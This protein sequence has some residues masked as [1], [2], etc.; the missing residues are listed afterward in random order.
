MT[1]VWLINEKTGGRKSRETFPLMRTVAT[2]TIYLRDHWTDHVKIGENRILTFVNID[3][4][5][6]VKNPN[7]NFEEFN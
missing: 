3:F 2:Q 4:R 6:N 7:K 5:Q 1:Q